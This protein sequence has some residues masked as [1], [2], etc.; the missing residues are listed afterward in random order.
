MA[1]KTL[2]FQQFNG[3]KHPKPEEVFAEKV[4][5]HNGISIQ[6]HVIGSSHHLTVGDIYTERLSCETDLPQYLSD[7]VHIFRTQTQRGKFYTSIWQETFSDNE[8]GELEASYLKE[9]WTLLHCFAP[10]SAFTAI[11]LTLTEI[12]TI[13][14]Y[15]EHS[16]LVFTKT[17]LPELGS[18]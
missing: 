7:K 10:N 11:R 18:T 2:F 13:H 6:L 5:Q 8:F 16:S 9:E 1:I 4:V 17:R 3:V 15:P 14:S 12:Y